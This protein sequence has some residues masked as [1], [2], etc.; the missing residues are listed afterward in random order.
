MT[1]KYQTKRKCYRKQPKDE[2]TKHTKEKNT[3]NMRIGRNPNN[4]QRDQVVGANQK[5]KHNDI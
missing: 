3:K 1:Q 5:L 4:K 2:S